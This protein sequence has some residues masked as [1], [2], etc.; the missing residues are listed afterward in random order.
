MVQVGRLN[1]W[2]YESDTE[3]SGHLK[4]ELKVTK[5]VRVGRRDPRTKP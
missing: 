4:L 3:E 2:I 1:C 5:R